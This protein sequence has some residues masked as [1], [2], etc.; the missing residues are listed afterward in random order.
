MTHQNR[1]KALD[2]QSSLLD[3]LLHA[4]LIERGLVI[5][6][7]SEEVAYYDQR[8]SYEDCPPAPNVPSLF[9]SWEQSDQQATAEIIP[10]NPAAAESLLIA[11]RS[12]GKVSPESCRR[13]AQLMDDIKSH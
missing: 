8:F 2:P 4:V 11:A 9:F 10:F 3:R 12:G 6:V 13:L 7:S 5:P 1:N